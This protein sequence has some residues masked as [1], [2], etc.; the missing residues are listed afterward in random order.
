MKRSSGI[1]A[2]VLLFLSGVSQNSWWPV[3]ANL[4][5]NYRIDTTQNPI[6]AVI[7][8]DS[9][10]SNGLTYYLNKI[11]KYC[12]TCVNSHLANDPFDSTYVLNR[13]PQFLDHAMIKIANNGFWFR[14]QHS[15][16]LYPLANTGYNWLYDTA[17]NIGATLI[18]K[19]VQTVFG[20]NDSLCCIKLSTNDTIIIS[21]SLGILQFPLGAHHSYRLAGV[22]G[23]VN[24][25]V[26]LKRFHDFFDLS[27]G[28]VLQ[29]AFTE[30]DYNIL[31]PLLKAGRERWDVLSVSLFADSVQCLVRKTHLDSVRYGGSPAVV[32]SYVSTVTVSFIDSAQHLANTYP[33]QEIFVSPYFVFNNGIRHIHKVTQGFD[34]QRVI[35][36]FGQICPGLYLGPGNTGAAAETPFANVFLNKNSSKIVGRQLTEGLGCTSELYNDYDRIYQNCLVGYIKGAD[37]SGVVYNDI[38]TGIRENT[39]NSH[40]SVFPV[41]AHDAVIISGL[42]GQGTQIQVF[43]S[44][45]RAVIT[46]SFSF[47]KT[48]VLN[49]AALANGPYF[50]VIS[51][52]FFSETKKLIIQH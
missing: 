50:I 8:V 18:S 32:S 30:D 5:Y 36:Q 46:T 22:E 25:G 52:Q 47:E 19:Q 37:T 23:I 27:A 13:Q 29:Y 12:D 20:N 43:N 24:A 26:K 42:N 14:G 7:K 3:R 21:K 17:Q 39:R 34:G 38:P 44:L 40:F 4:H 31:P 11:V 1:C 10:S 33:L 49:T 41:P 35:K 28:D 16:V 9:T 15:R 6:S 48:Q 51:D 45:G 2:F